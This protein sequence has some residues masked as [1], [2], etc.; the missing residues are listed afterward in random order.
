MGRLVLN[1]LS[2][3]FK[4][5]SAVK[6]VSLTVEDGDFLVLLGPSGCGKTTLL[7][8]IAGLLEPTS[9]S[10]ELDGTDITTA[11]SKKRDL[12]M[13]FQSYALY[14]HLSVSKNLAFP[15]H[16][17]RTDKQ[18]VK[19]RVEA[20]AEM[21]E[22]GHLLDRKPKEL[23][24]GQRQRVAVARALVRE[25]KAFLM[26]EPLSSLDAKLR[27]ATRQELA[28][29]HK[30]LG[31]TF[32]YVTHDQVEAMTMA[33][34]IALLNGGQLEQ[35]GTPEELYDK[36]ASVF[37]AGFLGSPATNLIDAELSTS[38]GSITV[39][40]PSVEAVLWDGETPRRDVVVGIRPEHLSIHAPGSAAAAPSSGAALRGIV[41]LAENLGSE[42]VIY[43]RV[44]TNRVAVRAPRGLRWEPGNAVVLSAEAK[45]LHLFD[46]ASGRRLEWQ[47]DAKHSSSS[48][49]AQPTASV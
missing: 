44:G 16:V 29:L 12:A 19:K 32:I 24:G 22:I 49:S 1:Q 18:E 40:A 47:A 7:R 39:M 45:K 11:P 14:P 37:A 15:L 36:P 43:C 10:L 35:L 34:R 42:Q 2:R 17:R 4:N 28:G 20:V 6:N 33:T 41:D 9:G 48:S 23:S 46:R 13:V 25:P 8:M 38:N 5:V 27:T 21:V 30:R 31:A 26:D 3:S